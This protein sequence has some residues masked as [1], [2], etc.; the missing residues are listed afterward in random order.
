MATKRTRLSIGKCSMLLCATLLLALCLSAPA[1][2]E[3]KGQ[4]HEEEMW[5]EFPNHLSLLL[6]GSFAH[7]E[8]ED[9][10]AETLGIDYEYRVNERLGL[11]IV[12][13]RAFDPVDSTTLLAVA[14]LHV[15]RGFAIQAGPGVEMID[16]REGEEDEDEFIVRLGALYEFEKG[17]FTV[18][19]QLH[20]DK[21][22]DA[23]T[24]VFGVAL[25]YGF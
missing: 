25:G 7:G 4:E 18:S 13:E 16:G 9:E 5:R 11:G 19:P 8:A 1:M 22:S 3:E 17:R 14:D 2:A 21:A 12:A 15:W 6:A 23:E 24:W 20:L 10:E